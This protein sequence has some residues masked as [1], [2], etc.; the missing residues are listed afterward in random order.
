MPAA[1]ILSWNTSAL[2]L[3]PVA[4]WTVPQRGIYASDG[5]A[6]IPGAQVTV[7][8]DGDDDLQITEHPVEQGT[9][10]S[11]HAFKRPCELRLQLGWSDAYADYANTTI[12]AIYQQI[13]SL[14]AGRIPFTVYTAKRTYQNMLVASC[15]VHTDA[16][17]AYTLMAD[18]TFKEVVLVATSVIAVVGNMMN[19]VALLDPQ[20][21]TAAINTGNLTLANTNIP[22]I[23]GG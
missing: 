15:R 1:N 9:Q 19:Q 16:R 14:Q 13:L 2:D 6:P 8:E 23:A 3:S 17:M 12:N 7:S 10:I 4:S 22:G 20:G 21:N 11:D 5:S 18:I